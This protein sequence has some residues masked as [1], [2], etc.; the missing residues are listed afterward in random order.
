MKNLYLK[1][2]DPDGHVRW[3]TMDAF[4]VT[5][6]T[7]LLDPEA[8]R[9]PK[10]GAEALRIDRLGGDTPNG[11]TQDASWGLRLSQP[12]LVAEVG[13][14]KL[15][16]FEI[17]LEVPLKIGDTRLVF[18][19]KRGRHEDG[20]W[21][22]KI[23]ESL[24]WY[25]ES[26]CGEALLKNV[27]RASESRLSIYLNGETGT[28]KEVLAKMIHQWSD[29]AS[30]PF[31]PINCGALPISLAESELF[32][33][34]KGA[35]TGAHRDRPGAFLQAHNGTLFLD[36]VGDLPAEIQVK[37]LRFLESGEIRSVGSDRLMHSSVRI[38]CATHQPLEKLVEQGKFRQDLYYRL[39]SVPLEVPSL[40]IRPEDIRALAQRFAR[41]FDKTLTQSALMYLEGYSW[42]GNVRELRHTVERAAGLAGREQSLI[43]E[44]DFEFLYSGPGFE[45]A[46]EQNVQS[47]M[48]GI[49]R[50]KDME[51]ILI[52]R[53]LKTASGNRT[54]A[55]KVLGVARSTLFEMIK[56]H[57]IVGSK[58]TDYWLERIR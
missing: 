4:P 2:Y 21:G 29:R 38:I 47:V 50:L 11:P 17:P 35:F 14:L 27:K 53:A 10:I 51:R 32:G 44:Q 39:A 54:E 5:F 28:G 26:D 23:G 42:P 3:K 43:Q 16:S 34:T 37:M 36:E 18:T 20:G 57:R 45:S 46:Q 58:S 15:Q 22:Q 56:R 52:L 1:I 24:P 13:D 12:G 6:G 40:R 48:P 25:T 55:A 8:L 9:D 19:L 31:V 41:E 49:F 7:Q 30:G 33:H